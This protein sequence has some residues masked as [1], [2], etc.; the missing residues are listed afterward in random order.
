MQILKTH[1]W[2]RAHPFPY[3]AEEHSRPRYVTVRYDVNVIYGP[4]PLR[5][6]ESGHQMVISLAA[7]FGLADDMTTIQR[8]PTPTNKAGGP[9]RLGER[10][11]SNSRLS[12]G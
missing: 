6:E 7:V 11:A 10:M 4:F 3:T 9:Y 12:N 1:K 5:I 8:R 2:L